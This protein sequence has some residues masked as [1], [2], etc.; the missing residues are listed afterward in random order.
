MY[1]SHFNIDNTRDIRLDYALF[2]PPTVLVI[3]GYDNLFYA[4]VDAVYSALEKVG[5]SYSTLGSIQHVKRRTP[6]RLGKF[7]K[8]L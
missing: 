4:V 3:D 7:V 1:D 6:K 8:F 5:G 2:T